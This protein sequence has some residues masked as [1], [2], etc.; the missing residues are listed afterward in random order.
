MD[1][2][3]AGLD[4][5]TAYLDDVLIKSKDRKTHFEHIIKVFERIEEY[6][7]KRAAEK[8]G[9]FMNE[10]KYLGQ[11]IDSDGRRSDP[12]RAE[13]IENMQPHQKNVVTLQAF[14][15]L[16]NY[17]GIYINKCTILGRH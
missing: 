4:L 14:L 6:G 17:H 16:A 9:I 5:V 15:G 1:T 10:I 12:A 8:C 11:I 3:L 2:M 13:V 7:F